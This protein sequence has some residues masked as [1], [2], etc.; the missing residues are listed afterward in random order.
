MVN[1]IQRKMDFCSVQCIYSD[2]STTVDLYELY[3]IANEK[4]LQSIYSAFENVNLVRQCRD[5]DNC[6]MCY[7]CQH[8]FCEKCA[9]GHYK[10]STRCYICNLQTHGVFNPAKDIIAKMKGEGSTVTK[11][12]IVDQMAPSGGSESD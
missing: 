8:Y 4:H 12:D 3:K 7:R 9:L 6:V 10:K 1:D 11:S 2:S 5:N